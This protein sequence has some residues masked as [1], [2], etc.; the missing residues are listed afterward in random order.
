MLGHEVSHVLARHSN[1]RLSQGQLANLG[2]TA[3][4][5]ALS[6]SSARAP[7]M[8][9]LGL[10]AQVGVLLPYS[11]IQESEADV[12]GLQLMAAAGFNPQKAINLWQNMA[13]SSNGKKPPRIVVYSPSDKNRIKE[14]DAQLAAVMPI[15][16]KAREMGRVTMPELSLRP[17]LVQDAR[18][19]ACVQHE[20][21]VEAYRQLLPAGFPLRDEEEREQF[22]QQR[23]MEHPCHTLVAE[24]D[25]AIVD[26]SFW[27]AGIFGDGGNI[28]SIYILVWRRGIGRQLLEQVVLDMRLAGFLRVGLWVMSG[29][30]RVERFLYLS[31]AFQYDGQT[32]QRAAAWQGG[33]VQRHMV[34]AL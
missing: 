12:L 34:R 28:L 11:R 21:W 25:G 3:A 4:D 23:V 18:E 16:D 31:Q 14:I 13:M 15:Y 27:G 30:V 32:R 6:D 10:G 5:I 22:R 17:A 2:M 29:N 1:E 20:S 9:A 8:A 26:L 24:I 7:A 19:I 33:Y